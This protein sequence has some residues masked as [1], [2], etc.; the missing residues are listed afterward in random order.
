MIKRYAERLGSHANPLQLIR[1]HDKNK[2]NIL[3]P[4]E[5]HEFLLVL[6]S[7]IPTPRNLRAHTRASAPIAIAF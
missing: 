2:D 3:D 5:L 6:T 7:L 1:K 4:D